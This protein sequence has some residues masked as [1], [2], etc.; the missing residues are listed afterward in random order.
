MPTSPVLMSRK[1][2]P[3]VSSPAAIFWIAALTELESFFSAL[4]IGAGRG[5]GVERNWST[6][7]PTPP[8][9]ASQAACEHAVAGLACDLEHDVD[10]GVLSQQLLG[11]GLTTGRDR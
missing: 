5:L 9:P 1:S 10:L 7:T 11:E 8:M 6:S 4:A 2:A 3:P